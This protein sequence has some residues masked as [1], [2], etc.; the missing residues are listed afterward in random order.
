MSSRS[1]YSA[2]MSRFG[3][4]CLEHI[5]RGFAVLHL[6]EVRGGTLPL[7]FQGHARLRR[8]TAAD[9]SNA[10]YP[11]L[12]SSSAQPRRAHLQ[13]ERISSSI[14]KSTLFTKREKKEQKERETTT[15]ELD[16]NSEAHS[17]RVRIYSEASGQK[18]LTTFQIYGPT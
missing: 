12:D 10:A 7:Y 17:H 8:Q 18:K 3:P 15:A 6:C 9:G 14:H 16:P 4:D 13:Q 1:V 5:R 2:V 11:Y